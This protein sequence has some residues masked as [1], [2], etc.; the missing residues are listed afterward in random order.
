M[1]RIEGLVAENAR[2]A[3][4]VAELQAKLGAPPKGPDNSSVPLSRGQMPSQPTKP[5]AKAKPHAG[6]HRPLHPNPTRKRDVFARVCGCGA[7][8]QRRPG[9]ARGL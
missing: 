1:A 7:D 9:A 4:L 8:V 6:A 2:L 5:K 3:A